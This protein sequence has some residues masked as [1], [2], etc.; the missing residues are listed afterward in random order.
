MK[1]EILK[2][3][4]ELH[5]TLREFGYTTDKVAVE[6]YGKLFYLNEAQIRAL[7]VMAKRKAEESDEA[8]AEFTN[9]VVVY[10]G[11]TKR[12]SLHTMTFR[13]DGSFV[14][15]F[16]RGFYDTCSNLTIELL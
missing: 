6:F 7:Q 14:E 15:C 2:V 11:R 5:N 3:R 1:L 8:F 16:E 10:S 9:N 12:K 13:K 4:K